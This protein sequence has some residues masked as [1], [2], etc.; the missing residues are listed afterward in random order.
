MTECI[1]VDRSATDLIR[2]VCFECKSSGVVD[3]WHYTG[4]PSMFKYENHAKFLDLCRSKLPKT[5][6]PIWVGGTGYVNAKS[7]I[8]K[9]PNGWC[10]DEFGRT[11]I[12]LDGLLMFQRYQLCDLIVGSP[13]GNTYD[14]LDSE[15]LQELTQKVES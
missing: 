8:F 3:P 12:L 4:N 6:L 13:N 15:R 7:D 10:E 9:C 11:V 5:T 1:C 2:S 14:A